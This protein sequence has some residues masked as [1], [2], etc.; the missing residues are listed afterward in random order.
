MLSFG[1]Q[2]KRETIAMY[3]GPP[4]AWLDRIPRRFATL[5][6]PIFGVLALGTP[7]VMW[8]AWEPEILG[9]GMAI[10][11]GSLLIAA[12]LAASLA[13]RSLDPAAEEAWRRT[14]ET[15]H[16]PTEQAKSDKRTWRDKA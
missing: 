11:V 1:N 8:M 2:D 16:K 10:G 4:D 7:L 14:Y 13:P 12:I 15:F 6:L 3:K 5:L 9:Y